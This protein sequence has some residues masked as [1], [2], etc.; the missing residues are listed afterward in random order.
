MSS[1]IAWPLLPPPFSLLSPLLQWQPSIGTEGASLMT[2]NSF[3][4]T[5]L[6]A[7]EAKFNLATLNLKLGGQIL[8]HS[9]GQGQNPLPRYNLTAF[10]ESPK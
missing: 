8:L 4:G 7:S 10:V 6:G 1:L 2:E 9:L 3:L 5:N